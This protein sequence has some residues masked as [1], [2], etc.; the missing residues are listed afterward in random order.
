M[1]RKAQFTDEAVFGWL[2]RRLMEVPAVTV[3]EVSKGTGVSVGSL[4]HRYGSLDGV[5][6]EAR[7]WALGRYH[8]RL[9]PILEAT[10]F[11]R[12]IRAA[13]QV[14]ACAVETPD[15]ALLVFVVPRQ[16]LVP[17]NAPPA[18]L[19]RLETIEA[20]EATLLA[21]YFAEFAIDPTVGMLAL[22]DIPCAVI[23]RA[24]PGPV[25]AE[26]SDAAIRKAF[27]ALLGLGVPAD[28]PPQEGIAPQI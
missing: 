1:G 23:S 28:A 9:I 3:Q 26:A 15:V 19:T 18:L 6:I 5:L 4:Y 10:G 25:D 20:T 13:L 27:R 11:R 21:A 2:A 12:G 8:L 14:L 24:L 17:Q 16:S 7:I 22:R